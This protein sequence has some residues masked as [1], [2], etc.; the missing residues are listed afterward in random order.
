MT[1][2]WNQ[3]GDGDDGVT[4]FVT[5]KNVGDWVEGEIVEIRTG[6]D[7]NNNPCPELVFDTVSGR[8]VWTVGQKVAQRVIREMAPQVG[9]TIHV[10]HHALGDAKRGQNPPKL[11]EVEI[12]DK[13]SQDGDDGSSDGQQSLA[14]DGAPTSAAQL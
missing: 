6:Q 10:R 14:V 11:F 9:W 2:D 12:I 8:K 3:W 5:F 7:F 13:P 4:E 1:Y